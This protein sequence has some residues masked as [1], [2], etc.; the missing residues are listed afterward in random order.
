MTDDRRCFRLKTTVAAKAS[1]ARVN[2][3]QAEAPAIA[4]PNATIASAATPA[5]RAAEMDDARSIGPAER[6]SRLTEA[7]IPDFPS[8]HGWHVPFARRLK[9]LPRNILATNPFSAERFAWWPESGEAVAPQQIPSSPLS[10]AVNSE[11]SGSAVPS[12]AV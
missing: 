6:I 2:T 11:T 8:H 12:T 7:G 4:A 9:T 10:S 5:S 3:S 1:R